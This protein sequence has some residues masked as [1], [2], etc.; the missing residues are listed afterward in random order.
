LAKVDKDPVAFAAG[1]VDVSSGNCPGVG[2]EEFGNLV[3][4]D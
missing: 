1:A 4:L 2:D 3:V